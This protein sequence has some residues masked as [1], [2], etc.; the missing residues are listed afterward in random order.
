MEAISISK[1]FLND[2]IFVKY[3]KIALKIKE[4]SECRYMKNVREVIMQKRQKHIVDINK[5]SQ[6][7]QFKLIDKNDNVNEP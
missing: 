1:Q 6:Y 5:S 2:E 7:K 4:G 3:P